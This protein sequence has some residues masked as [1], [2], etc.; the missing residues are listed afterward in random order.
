MAEL[1]VEPHSDRKMILAW[2][3]KRK[4]DIVV[5]GVVV[6]AAEPDRED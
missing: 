1:G 2:V 5:V 4:N 3:Y 6:A